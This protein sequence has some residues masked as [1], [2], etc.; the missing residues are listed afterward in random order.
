[1]FPTLKTGDLLIAQSGIEIDEIFSGYG[2]GDIIVFSSPAD[3][4]I[5]VVH[6][7][8]EKV[9]SGG[10]VYLRTKGD[11]NPTVD[12][13]RVY[14]RHLAGK[15]LEV[16]S[17]P[18]I[19]LSQSVW[20][21]TAIGLLVIFSVLTFDSTKLGGKRREENRRAALKSVCAATPGGQECPKILDVIS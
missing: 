9:E 7:A 15:V 8:V 5:I 3:A 2:T 14:D 16:N 10:D 19:V 17:L 12:P 21:L 20:W 13:W 11:Y 18:A 1:M 4:R 6:R